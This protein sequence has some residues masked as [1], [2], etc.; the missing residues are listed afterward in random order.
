MIP[1]IKIRQIAARNEGP[2][3]M[4]SDMIKNKIFIGIFITSGNVSNTK[5]TLFASIWVKLIISPLLN[6]LFVAGDRRRIFVQIILRMPCL[7]WVPTLSSQNVIFSFK[8]RD[9]NN[10]NSISMTKNIALYSSFL[11]VFSVSI[12]FMISL[13][14]KGDETS[15]RV[16][17]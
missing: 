9:K 6:R 3:N 1:N 10:T 12:Y 11:V 5:V 2:M 8:I 16:P 15:T 14:I 13:S 7:A 4:Y 17:S